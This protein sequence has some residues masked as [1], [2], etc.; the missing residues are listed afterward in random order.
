MELNE[1]HDEKSRELLIKAA[2]GDNEAM[3]ALV[4]KNTGLVWSGKTIHK[5]RCGT[6]RSISN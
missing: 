1:F 4:E 3:S 5:Q 2:N 6:G